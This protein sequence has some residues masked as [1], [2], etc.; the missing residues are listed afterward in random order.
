M[1]FV[2]GTEIQRDACRECLDRSFGDS[3]EIIFHRAFV[4]HGRFG[5]GK[6]SENDVEYLAFVDAWSVK[7]L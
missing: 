2:P 4:R 5:F 1:I 3:A 6:I 7:F